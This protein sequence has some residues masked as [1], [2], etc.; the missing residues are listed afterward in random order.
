MSPRSSWGA[1]VL[2][3]AA[4]FLWGRGG[5]A[6][7]EA[8]S[9]PTFAFFSYLQSGK[10][11]PALVAYSPT[12]YDPRPG[13]QRKVPTAA[14]LQEDLKALRP[15]FDGLILYGYDR[16]VTPI[17]LAEAER[18]EY[19]AVLL[20]IWNPKS[21]RELEDTAELVKRYH[22]KLALAVSL[23]NEG[24]A[25]NRYTMEDLKRA[26]TQLQRLLGPEA[27]VPLCTSEPLAEWAQRPLREFGSF[28]AVNVHPVYDK[29]DLGPVDAAAWA[30][31]RARAIAELAGKPVLVKET[32]FPNGGNKKFSPTAQRQFWEAY[33]EK[34]I[35]EKTKG[36]AK[37]WVSFAAA[38]EAYSLPWK[39]EE[40]GL[41]VEGYWGLM[42]PTR[43]PF[44][45]FE[46]WRRFRERP[47]GGMPGNK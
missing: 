32:G 31:G 3:V 45:A 42:N 21:K 34:G 33:L 28:L 38:F 7:R 46:V 20:G 2:G 25:F 5:E 19:R 6:G 29:P 24:L 36:R 40:T 15:A 22:K 44:P 41:P 14:S 9:P 10:P 17:I 12:N 4:L 13:K 1:C 11:T 8:P 26:E 27:Q 23:G 30:R 43:E 39:A 47:G 37:T 18:Q 16:Q 35:L